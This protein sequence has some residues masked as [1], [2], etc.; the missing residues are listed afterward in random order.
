[1]WAGEE[2]VPHRQQHVTRRE[3][4]RQDVH[5]WGMGVWRHPG[6]RTLE[7]RVR[8]GSGE[9]AL[10]PDVGGRGSSMGKGKGYSGEGRWAW[11]V[12]HPEDPGMGVCVCCIRH[13]G[14][15]AGS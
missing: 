7:R 9:G 5:R 15:M 11:C 10:Q 6:G 3:H 2:S 13:W 8:S 12:D 4:E 14:A 1:M